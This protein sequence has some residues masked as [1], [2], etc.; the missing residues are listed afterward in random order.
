MTEQKIIEILQS[1]DCVPTGITQFRAEEDGAP[2]NV[3][4]VETPRGPAVLKKTTAR[5]R[6]TYETFFPDG[7]GVPEIYVFAEFQRE[8]YILME[9]IGGQTMSRCD[10]HRLTLTLDAL[11]AMQA[12]FWEDRTHEAVGY[13]FSESWPNRQKRLAY[14]GDLTAAYQAYLDAF[15]TVPRTL[16]NDDLLPFNVLADDNRAVIIDWEYGGI[17]PYP[18]ALARLLAFGEEAPDA[19]FCMTREDQRFAVDYYYEK[20]VRSKGIG[21]GEYIRTLKLFFLK[22]YSEWVY[23]AASSGDFSGPY[24]E[25]YYKMAKTLAKDLGL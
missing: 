7:G 3:W 17:L 22:E 18:S 2:Y 19:M 15:C 4:K 13:G 8:P 23:C 11:I 1:L 9:Y 5:E 14:M 25:K 12:R 20:L 10:R 6:E 16:C 24:Y 21:Y